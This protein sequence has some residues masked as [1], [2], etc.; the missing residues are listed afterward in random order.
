ME[1]DKIISFK[2]LGID[3]DFNLED[4]DNLSDEE[5]E[6]CLDILDK[7]KNAIEDKKN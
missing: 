4:F 5:L 6:E 1:D 3:V 7:L 2:D